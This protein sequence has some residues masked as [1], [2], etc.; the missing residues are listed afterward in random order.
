MHIRRLNKYNFFPTSFHISG[1]YSKELLIMPFLLYRFPSSVFFLSPSSLHP[2]ENV[3]LRNYIG[4]NVRYENLL[5]IIERTEGCS[6]SVLELL[7][8]LFPCWNHFLA[9]S[10]HYLV[11]SCRNIESNRKKKN[12]CKNQDM[13]AFTHITSIFSGMKMGTCIRSLLSRHA[14]NLTHCQ[15]NLLFTTLNLEAAGIFCQKWER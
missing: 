13:N 15:W 2:I 10:Q 14:Y 1:W 9:N 5:Q 3:P 12:T 7:F 6:I 11:N 4:P 8:R